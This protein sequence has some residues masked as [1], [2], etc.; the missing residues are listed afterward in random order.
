MRGSGSPNVVV[1]DLCTELA[2]AHAE[3]ADLKTK[4]Q[5]VEEDRKGKE[6]E[7]Q[8]M[9][10]KVLTSDE[11]LKNMIEVRP[12]STKLDPVTDGMIFRNANLLRSTRTR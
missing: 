10:E 7:L 11:S 3:N 9:Q 1:V 4:L 8:S 12:C 6:K 5:A 2:M